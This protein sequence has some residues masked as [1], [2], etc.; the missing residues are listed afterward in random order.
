MSRANG[1]TESEQIKRNWNVWRAK[2]ACVVCRQLYLWQATIYW[3]IAQIFVDFF[4][5][6]IDIGEVA[7]TIQ[8]PIIADS[9]LNH[10]ID[11]MRTIQIRIRS[12]M[13][14]VGDAIWATAWLFVVNNK[15]ARITFAA[16]AFIIVNVISG[17]GGS[18]WLISL[19]VS[20]Y[21]FGAIFNA[22]LFIWLIVVAVVVED[23]SQ[24]SDR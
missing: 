3:H 24:L 21:R 7:I 2:I 16:I 6:V 1:T 10:I 18:Y 13:I 23:C 4:F 19:V 9:Q 15:T 17:R 22:I 20:C 14:I 5:N 8:I 11:D 12:L